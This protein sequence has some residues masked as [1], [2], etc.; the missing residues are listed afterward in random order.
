MQ[1]IPLIDRRVVR[2]PRILI[3]GDGSRVIGPPAQRANPSHLRTVRVSLTP[4]TTACIGPAIWPPTLTGHRIVA[5]A[6]HGYSG[7]RAVCDATAS[8]PP[9]S[10]VLQP[11]VDRNVRHFAGNH[12]SRTHSGR[13][14]AHLLDCRYLLTCI[15]C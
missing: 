11:T 8:A 1:L 13:L 2:R 12:L 9:P 15:N 5:V 6:T 10:L 4:F 14:D 3:R 7:P